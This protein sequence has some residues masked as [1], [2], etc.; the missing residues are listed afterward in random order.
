VPWPPVRVHEAGAPLQAPAPHATPRA[1]APQ[2]PEALAAPRSDRVYAPPPAVPPPPPAPRPP[3]GQP[4]SGPHSCTAVGRYPPSYHVYCR[5]ACQACR[6]LLLL[7]SCRHSRCEAVRSDAERSEAAMR[8]G[9]KK[10]FWNTVGRTSA[11]LL[12]SQ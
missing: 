2:Q 7:S 12:F 4:N 8:C 11:T 9:G 3:A 6:A 10:G 1:P 5:L